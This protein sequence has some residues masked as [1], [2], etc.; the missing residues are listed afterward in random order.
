[1]QY[2]VSR[3]YYIP[4]DPDA[5]ASALFFNLWGRRC[6]P[7][8]ALEI[9]DVLYW[10]YTPAKTIV[11]RSRTTDV[12]R[13]EY[14]DKES[15]AMTLMA[16]FGSFDRQ[17]PYFLDATNSGFC[18]AYKV[19]PLERLAREKPRYLRFPQLGWLKLESAPA[20]QWVGHV[21]PVS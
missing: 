5:L 17:D 4:D 9:G 3:P 14:R 11:W 21:S 13:F 19:Q 15:V 6:W 16:R 20:L 2:V 12:D 10:Y 7:Y 1:M 8:K 18:L